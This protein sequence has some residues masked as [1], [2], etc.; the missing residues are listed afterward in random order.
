MSQILSHQGEP[1]RWR[2]FHTAT[3]IGNF[4]YIFGGRSDQGGNV[5]TNNE[6]YCNKLQIFDTSTRTWIEPE[7]TGVLPIGR[8]SHSACK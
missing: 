2:D 3:G 6:I 1:A 5:Y 7:T 8:R 4:M